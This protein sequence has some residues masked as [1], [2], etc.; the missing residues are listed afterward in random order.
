MELPCICAL[1]V[2][3][4]PNGYNTAMGVIESIKNPVTKEILFDTI[5]KRRYDLISMR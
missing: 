2:L 5:E 4:F 1:R 3:G